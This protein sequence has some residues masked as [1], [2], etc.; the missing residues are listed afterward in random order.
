M[1]GLDFV[2][3]LVVAVA[4]VVVVRCLIADALRKSWRRY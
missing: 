3:G 2:I 4:I 1:T